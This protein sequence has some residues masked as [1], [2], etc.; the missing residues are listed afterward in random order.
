MQLY[1]F[2]YEYVNLI[3]A[4]TCNFHSNVTQ[5]SKYPSY[6]TAYDS[7]GS[8]LS[9]SN[10]SQ[11]CKIVAILMRVSEKVRKISGENQKG[12]NTVLRCSIENQKSAIAV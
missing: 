12:V 10:T 2:S 9:I 11:Y 1:R 4:K 6:N 5:H 8:A 7:L 3:F